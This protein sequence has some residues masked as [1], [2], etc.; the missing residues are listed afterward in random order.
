[1]WS[2]KYTKCLMQGHVSSSFKYKGEE[3]EYCVRCGKISLNYHT[4]SVDYP[5]SNSRNITG[6]KTGMISMMSVS[7]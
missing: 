1:M 2:N 5:E 3:Y 6:E 7:K 4:S